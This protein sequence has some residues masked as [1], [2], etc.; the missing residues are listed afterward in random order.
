[1]LLTELKNKQGLEIPGIYLFSNTM[2]SHL[3]N[4]PDPFEIVLLETVFVVWFYV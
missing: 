2:D 4:E 3:H 1:M